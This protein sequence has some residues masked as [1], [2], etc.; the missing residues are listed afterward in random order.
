MKFLVGVTPIFHRYLTLLQSAGPLVHCIL[1]EMKLLLVSVLFRFIKPEVVN[2]C[3][4]TKDLL[5][6][7]VEDKNNQLPAKD[8]DF[9][10]SAEGEVC[11][12]NSC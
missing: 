3:K 7:D 8:I 9:G 6:I 5:E 12:I 10:S 1:D 4:V 11:E 2:R